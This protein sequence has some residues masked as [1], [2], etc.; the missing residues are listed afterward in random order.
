MSTSILYDQKTHK[1]GSL[2]RCRMRRVGQNRTYTLYMTVC[3]VIPLP[4]YRKYT[5]NMY[6][7]MV[8][9][10]PTYETS[11]I[12]TALF[13]V[14]PLILPQN[15]A[16]GTGRAWHPL[17]IHAHTALC[18][19]LL[20]PTSKPRT[21]DWSCLASIVHSCP[22]STV[23]VTSEPYTTKPRTRDWSCL[24]SIVHSCPHST[25]RV[26]LE[27]Y[28]TKPRTRD[29]S[30]L[31]S[32]VHSCPH[33][34]VRVTSESYTTKPRTRDWSCLPSASFVSLTL[35]RPKSPGRKERNTKTNDQKEEEEKRKGA[36]QA[37]G[38]AAHINY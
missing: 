14:Y 32:I 12:Y 11:S 18:V 19:L 7:C 21:R 15:H 24:P 33:S 16:P 37:A 17:C 38:P 31:A 10:H 5:V 26:T 28:T 30:C 23:R 35:A 4:K 2:C 34:T 6:R 27:P 25:V 29:W 8:L 13:L 22:H 20:N 9:A 3:M 1:D 36:T